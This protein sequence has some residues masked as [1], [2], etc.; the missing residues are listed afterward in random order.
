MTAGSLLS[1]YVY[2]YNSSLPWML[3]PVALVILGVLFITQIKEE[4]KVED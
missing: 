4:G 1:G 3:L 2:R